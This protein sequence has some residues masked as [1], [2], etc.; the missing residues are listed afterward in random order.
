MA[1][2]NL[3]PRR[4][5]WFSPYEP[6]NKYDIWLSKNAH[7]DENGESITDSDAQRDCD[8]IFKIYDCGKWQPIVGF[9]STARYKINIVDGVDYTYTIPNTSTSHTNNGFQQNHLPLFRNPEDSPNELF[10]AGT[11]GQALYEFV[12]EEE[13]NTLFDADWFQSAFNTSIIGGSDYNWHTLINGNLDFATTTNC[14]G[15]YSDTHLAASPAF[16]PIEVKFY[17]EVQGYYQDE[18][19]RL[20]VSAKDVI[21]QINDYYEDNPE[22]SY[23][24]ILKNS[25]SIGFGDTLS[26]SS[27]PYDNPHVWGVTPQNQGKFLRI[28]NPYPSNPSE[29]TGWTQQNNAM[30]WVDIQAGIGTNIEID[31]SIMTVST[32]IESVELG[33]PP[34]SLSI[35]NSNVSGQENSIIIT[36]DN[37][38]EKIVGPYE[39]FDNSLTSTS[40]SIDISM[41]LSQNTNPIYLNVNASAITLSAG[42]KYICDEDLLSNRTV[43]KGKFLITIQFGIVKIEKIV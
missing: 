31:E 27:N 24:N 21:D 3:N 39:V 23:I 40:Y 28:R 29:E 14:G 26:I 32:N 1:I 33:N 22:G 13:W 41:S 9:N 16:K 17:P 7:Y 10:D 8:Y 2:N 6:L 35:A 4:T 38:Y 5:V 36:G 25:S 37:N 12:T 34:A 19:H 18:R 30:E 20:C 43:E 42:T 11:L 15:I